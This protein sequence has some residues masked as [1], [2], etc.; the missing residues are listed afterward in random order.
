MKIV[1]IRRIGALGYNFIR[2]NFLGQ[3]NFIVE[4]KIIFAFLKLK[5]HFDF[6]STRR[7][8][9]VSEISQNMKTAPISAPDGPMSSSCLSHRLPSGCIL[10]EFL[11]HRVNNNLGSNQICNFYWISSFISWYFVGT[12]SLH[13]IRGRWLPHATRWFSSSSCE[14]RKAF[15]RRQRICWWVRKAS[16]WL[17]HSFHCRALRTSR[18][19][20]MYLRHRS[21]A[22]KFSIFTSHFK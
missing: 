12:F 18:P 3:F 9:R 5:L 8:V 1:P 20:W 16:L 22:M 21:L 11:H 14:L 2:Y 4:C 13:F 15:Y 17:R 7:T 6:T 10:I 19:C